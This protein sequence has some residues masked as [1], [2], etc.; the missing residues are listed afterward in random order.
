MLQGTG[1]SDAKAER[2]TVASPRSIALLERQVDGIY[3][4]H[5]MA[6]V[7]FTSLVDVKALYSDEYASIMDIEGVRSTLRSW[8]ATVPARDAPVYRVFRRPPLAFLPANGCSTSN[9]A[10]RLEAKWA[11]A[12]LCMQ[13]INAF[14]PSSLAAHSPSKAT[15]GVQ[16]PAAGPFYRVLTSLHKAPLAVG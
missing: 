5:Q 15:G 1:R 14:A 2:L 10:T 6:L 7:A 3:H 4:A 16:A 12:G 13:P 8:P 9:H 11:M